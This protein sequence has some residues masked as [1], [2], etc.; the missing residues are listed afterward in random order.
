MMIWYNSTSPGMFLKT[1]RWGISIAA[2]IF[3]SHYSS[4]TAFADTILEIPRSDARL[5]CADDLTSMPLVTPESKK[6]DTVPSLPQQKP[7]SSLNSDILFD[8]INSYRMSIGLPAFQKDPVICEIAKQRGPQLDYEVETGMIHAG[9]RAL[10]LPYWATENV[11]YGGNEQDMFHWWMNSSIHRQALT[12]DYKY[13]C[14]ECF[15]KSCTQIFTNYVA[16]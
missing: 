13:S 16:K 14:G 7:S 12:G 4:P 11:K 1:V 2:V 6:L 10:E 3:L 15:G 8:I 9:F 5:F